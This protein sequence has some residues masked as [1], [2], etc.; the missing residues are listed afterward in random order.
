MNR[1]LQ[2][3]NNCRSILK[4]T[5]SLTVSAKQ[6]SAVT[7]AEQRFSDADK[8]VSHPIPFSTAKLGPFTQEEPKLRNQYL[9]DPLLKSYIH[10]YI[11]QKVPD[12]C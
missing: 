6:H 1:V 10:R 2:L 3:P 8:E 4:R 7:D 9:E 12:T 5:A 11:P